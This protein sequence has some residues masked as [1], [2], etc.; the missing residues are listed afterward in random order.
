M[1]FRRAHWD[2][3]PKSLADR[4]PR[5]RDLPAAARRYLFAEA[6][7]FLLYDLETDGGVNEDVFAFTNRDGDERALVLV[8]S[9]FAE[10]EGSLRTSAPLLEAGRGGGRQ[11]SSASRGQGP[12]PATR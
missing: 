7:D 11:S 12:R 10:A 5:A 2:E 6:R 1:E 9:R 8:H 4:A 3:Q